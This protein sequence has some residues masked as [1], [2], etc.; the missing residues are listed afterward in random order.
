MLKHIFLVV[1]AVML[2]SNVVL[3]ESLP[4][5]ETVQ[6]VFDFGEVLRGQAVT[7]TFV[8]RNVGDAT[9][10]VDRVKSTCGCTGVLLSEKSIPPGAEGTVKATFNSSRFQGKVE[11]K[12]LLYSNDPAG[13]PVTFTV[14]GV[15]RIPL[16]SNPARISFGEVSVGQSKTVAA[17]LTNLSDQTVKISNLRTSNS[18]IRAEV[19][20]D[21]LKSNET[22]QL[23]VIASANAKTAHLSGNVLIRLDQSGSGEIKIPVSGSVVMVE[24][25]K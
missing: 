2:T 5:I 15:V 16:E 3:A 8:F 24:Q 1:M 9:L 23:R 7:H 21:T 25:N 6:P 14:K 22:T 4:R 10:V 18:D 13:A 11:K 19:D 20:S 17:V 12:I